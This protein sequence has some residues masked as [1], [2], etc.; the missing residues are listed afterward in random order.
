MSLMAVLLATV[1]AG[2]GTNKITKLSTL[3]LDADTHDPVASVLVRCTI[4]K[5]FTAKAVEQI[6]RTD[7]NGR[8]FFDGYTTRRFTRMDV[9]EVPNGYHKLLLCNC[10]DWNMIRARLG[11][12]PDE[13]VATQYLSKVGNPIPLMVSY[14]RDCD[15]SPRFSKCGNVCRFDLMKADWLPPYGTGEVADIVF[16]KTP[17]DVMKHRQEIMVEFPG[18]GN[19]V[20]EIENPI[21]TTPGL[22]IAPE[23]GYKATYK[24][25]S[26]GNDVSWNS[27]PVLAFRIRTET[28]EKGKITGGYYGKIYGGIVMYEYDWPGGADRVKMRYYLNPNSLDRNLEWDCKTNLSPNPGRQSYLYNNP[29]P[30]PAP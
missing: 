25:Y 19:G 2:S 3:V 28:D 14:R 15:P 22:R 4:Y 1:L 8:A 10:Q 18:N 30:Y 23:D 26:E 17:Y 6:K 21:Q 13:L 27:Q 29:H 16:R 5:D 9:D 11:Y 7:Q 20:K 24:M 12:E